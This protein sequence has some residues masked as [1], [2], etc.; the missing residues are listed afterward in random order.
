MKQNSRFVFGFCTMVLA[1]ACLCVTS[2]T[3][4]VLVTNSYSSLVGG[5]WDFALNWSSGAPAF[6]QS[7]ET[8]TNA[9]IKNISIVDTTAAASL[10]ISNLNMSG[11]PAGGVNTL[12][13]STT[14]TF[15]VLQNIV[16]GS[17][18]A[19]I[20]TNATVDVKGQAGGF[21]IVNGGVTINNGASF[22]A[23]NAASG[24]D[25]GH[26]GSGTLTVNGGRLVVIDEEVGTFA[27]DRGTLTIAGGTNT[28][29]SDG[30][31]IGDSSSSTGIVWITSGA[32]IETN[33]SIYVGNLGSGRLTV[34]NGSVLA[35][36]LIIGNTA[37]GA[38]TLTVAGGDVQTPDTGLLFPVILGQSPGGT[39]TMW[40]TSGSFVSTNGTERIGDSGAGTIVV[41]N[42]TMLLWRP[43]LGYTAGAGT[44]NVAGGSVRI[45]GAGVDFSIGDAAS[46][47]GTVV[48]T[49]GEI[50]MTNDVS[51]NVFIGNAGVGSWTQSGGT[52]NV[53]DVILANG[54][55]GVGTLTV[56]GGLLTGAGSITVGEGSGGTG[57][58]WMTGGLLSFTDKVTLVADPVGAVGSITVSNGTAELRDVTIG[59]FGNGALTMAGGTLH[60]G[61]SFTLAGNSTSS[62]NFTQTGGWLITTNAPS[63]SSGT[64]T[65]QSSGGTWLASGY[66]LGFGNPGT[67]TISGG[68]NIFGGGLNVGSSSG[69]GTVWVTSGQLTA[70]NGAT[71]IGPGSIGR[72][73][74]SNGVVQLR[75]VSIASGSP[76]GRLIIAGGTTTIG[77]PLTVGIGF[78][79]TGVVTVSSG[80][81]TMTN[82]ALGFL[83][84]TGTLAVNGGNVQA[85]DVAVGPTP[86]GG[87]GRLILNGGVLSLNSLLVPSAS[88]FVAFTKG[89][90]N[91]AG[92]SVS[93]GLQF[94]VG[95]GSSNATYHLL[96]GIHTFGSGLRVR[97]NAFLTGCGT[98]NGN[99]VVEA[100]GR[101]IADCG[102]ILTFTGSVTNNGVMRAVNGSGLEAYGS[103]VNNGL[104][105]VIFGSTNFHSTFINTGIVLD[106][107]SDFDGDG[108]SNL[109]EALAGTDPTNNASA[110]R[111]T[112]IVSTGSDVLVNWMTGIGRTNALQVTAGT[113]DG[114]YATNSFANLFIVT[115]TVGTV[116]NYLDVGG[117]TN[118]PARYYRVRLVP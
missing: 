67:F 70:T 18:G 17:G 19:M 7:C 98:I 91:S 56:G 103:V 90:L 78:G 48:L 54:A 94:A 40:V 113:G 51:D 89:T 59:V 25:I 81:L 105:D 22:L 108:L 116:T 64:V 82:V 21:V 83:F 65:I 96:G 77:G 87:N 11:P 72:L 26:G 84:S 97:T 8:I 31:F 1:T 102:G 74:V 39:G 76:D 45:T 34:S 117:A 79:A 93:N 62:A 71:G 66:T 107:N 33:T 99:V 10:I 41:S 49:G 86:P 60:A 36:Q 37:G 30:L 13:L 44:L 112:S 101:V 57:T 73:T 24:V 20:V 110:F 104:I 6:G 38:G 5:P 27:G 42:G 29:T 15:T 9:G 109:Q 3:R 100:G 28:V 52:G 114:S 55:G 23:T 115:N 68:T 14:N 111:I 4:A 12:S 80:T 35:S 118:S 32:L 2:T 92:A 95:N 88:S 75:D 46:T 43:F 53:V 61:V 106:A 85:Y 63:I 58:V 50:V 69:S 16:L 47:R